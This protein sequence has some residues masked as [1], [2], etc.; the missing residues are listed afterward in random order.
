MPATLGKDC[1][2]DAGKSTLVALLG[3]EVAER[4][5]AGHLDEAQS[6]LRRALPAD[7]AM[8]SW[9]RNAFA[10]PPQSRGQVIDAGREFHGGLLPRS[11]RAETLAASLYSAAPG[12][13]PLG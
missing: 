10:M 5:L 11:L 2:K 13:R 12:P 9:V 6:Q 8:V 1:N 3:L 7:E 4:R